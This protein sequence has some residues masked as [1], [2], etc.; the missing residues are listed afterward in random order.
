VVETPDA[1]PIA[2]VEAADRI[3]SDCYMHVTTDY[4]ITWLPKPTTPVVVVVVVAILS[5]PSPAVAIPGGC[6]PV[7]WSWFSG[8]VVIEFLIVAVPLFV[9][10]IIPITSLH[11]KI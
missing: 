10:F 2:K 9:V 11:L 5:L 3:P 7:L 1:S 8:P 6:G 4:M